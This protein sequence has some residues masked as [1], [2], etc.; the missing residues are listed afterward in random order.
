[1]G[2]IENFRKVAD[3]LCVLARSS[4]SDRYLMAVG[5]CQLK[6]VPAITGKSINDAPALKNAIV[7]LSMGIEGTNI[8]K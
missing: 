8:A 1:M 7:G 3:Q 4:P 2:N 6:N 5:L